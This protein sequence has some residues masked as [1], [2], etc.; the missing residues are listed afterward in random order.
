MD[1]KASSQVEAPAATGRA[2]ARSVCEPLDPE[3]VVEE[4]ADLVYAL[5][6]RLTRHEEEARELFQESFVRILRGLRSFEGR[7]SPRTWICQVV[8]NCDRNRRR[9]WSRLRRNVP[10]VSLTAPAE[11]EAP[12][13]EPA[14]PSPGPDRLALSHEARERLESALTELPEEQRVAVVLRDVE[15]MSYEE[16]AAAMTIPVGTVKS[17]IARAR[18]ALRARLSDLVECRG[19][20]RST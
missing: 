20:E 17:K 15:G 18:S 5:A 12:P 7:S 16:I 4:Y 19:A 8:I 2:D 10:S 6:R 11:E 13:P 9:F 3:R 1:E 14:D